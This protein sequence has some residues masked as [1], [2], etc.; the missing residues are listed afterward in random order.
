MTTIC[1][2]LAIDAVSAPTAGPLNPATINNAANACTVLRIEIM[3]Q[4]SLTLRSG[5]RVEWSK[6]DS[7]AACVA[8]KLTDFMVTFGH[9]HHRVRMIN[10]FDAIMQS[11]RHGH[12]GR[13]VDHSVAERSMELKL[14][15]HESALVTGAASGIGRGIAAALAREGARVLLCDID[16]PLGEEAAAELRRE[17][18]DASFAA[19][20]LAASDGVEIL[21]KGALARFGTP[22]MF[23]HA[24]SPRRLERD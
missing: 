24:A 16:V 17:G 11:S 8:K 23:V 15:I 12:P 5:H 18:C 19:A 21:L 14:L 22:S 2:I 1:L 20:D 10:Q 13:I 9:Y 3:S 4:C 7:V 6:A